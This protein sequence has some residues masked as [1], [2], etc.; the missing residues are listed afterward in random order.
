MRDTQ[1]I[2]CQFCN[3][4]FKSKSC[5]DKHMK[6]KHPN[7][8]E[9]KVI[10][11]ICF[12]IIGI[13]SLEDHKKRQHSEKLKKTYAC[14]FCN[15]ESE[16]KSNLKTHLKRIHKF[17][18]EEVLCNICSVF[19]EKHLLEIHEKEK[20]F[21]ERKQFSCKFCD[22]KTF[23]QQNVQGHIE[24]RHS[25][26]ED[27]KIECKICK[28][29]YRRSTMARHVARMHGKRHNVCCHNCNQHFSSIWEL[30]NHVKSKTCFVLDLSM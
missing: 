4:K 24:R 16:R 19:I 9:K 17:Q 2:S 20:H 11:D 30:T 25:E 26:L 12:V 22:F 13:N 15:Y 10:C 8:E 21:S 23:Y 29:F 28:H 3:K 1:S 27:E 14:K 6:N 5:L 7:F 18:E